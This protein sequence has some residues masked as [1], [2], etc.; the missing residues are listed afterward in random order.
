[1]DTVTL[2]IASIASNLSGFAVLLVIVSLSALLAFLSHSIVIGF[3]FALLGTV[4]ILPLL[5]LEYVTTINLAI[6]AGIGVGLVALEGLISRRVRERSAKR[7]SELAARVTDLERAEARRMLHAMESGL[8]VET[9]SKSRRKK[10]TIAP[11]AT[12]EVAE[13]PPLQNRTA[14]G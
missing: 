13:S 6:A 2:E 4:S 1:M 12:P 3:A 8:Q 10:P 7:Y 14:S 11:A 5:G 9:Q